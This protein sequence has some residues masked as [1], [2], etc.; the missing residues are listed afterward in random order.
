MRQGVQVQRSWESPRLRPDTHDGGAKTARQAL[1]SP[2][3]IAS[4]EPRSSG[5]RGIETPAQWRRNMIELRGS[6]AAGLPALNGLEGERNTTGMAILADKSNCCSHPSFFLFGW[7]LGCWGH[8]RHCSRP[9]CFRHRKLIWGHSLC[10]VIIRQ[11]WNAWSPAPKWLLIALFENVF[12]GLSGTRRASNHRYTKEGQKKQA[13]PVVPV[14]RPFTME[15]ADHRQ[16]RQRLS[17]GTAAGLSREVEAMRS[18]SAPAPPPPPSRSLSRA[19]KR[20]DTA[21]QLGNTQGLRESPAVPALHRRSRSIKHQYG[22]QVPVAEELGD[23][24]NGQ[25]GMTIL[26]P[27]LF[28]ATWLGI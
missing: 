16:R 18:S 13:M 28:P 14:A 3:T 17:L 24:D 23:Q 2:R 26:P 21:C 6:S 5:G 22:I 20:S 12:A 10:D 25:K 7:N 27:R 8:I 9:S 1:P 4:L 19:S 15:T 11:H